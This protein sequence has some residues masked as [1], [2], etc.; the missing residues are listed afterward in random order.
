MMSITNPGA[1]LMTMVKMTKSGKIN[2]SQFIEQLGWNKYTTLEMVV[3]E[4]ET[5]IRITEKTRWTVEEATEHFN[6]LFKSVCKNRTTHTIVHDGHE[7]VLVP[8]DDTV[9]KYLEMQQENNDK[10]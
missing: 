5:S 2:I 3:D 7:Y 6:K 10:E 4:H 1:F 9:H 8:Y